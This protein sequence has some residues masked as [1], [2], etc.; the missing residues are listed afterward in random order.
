MSPTTPSIHKRFYAEASVSAD[1]NGRCRVLLDGRGVRTPGKRELAVPS[2]DLAEA[3]AEEWRSQ[4][5]NIDPTSMPM[6]R[7]ANSA[8]DGVAGREREVR[9]DLL[10]FAG[11]DLLCYLADGPPELA[12]RQSRMWGAIHAWAKCTHGVEL[13]LAVGI[14]PVEQPTEMMARLDAAFGE[15]SALELAGLH[16]VTTLTGSALLALAVL[17]EKVTAAEAWSLA[18]IDEDFQIERWGSDEEASARRA[19]RWREMEAACRVV[20]LS[21]R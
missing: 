17:H 12:E 2:A 4:G 1:V 11:S 20:M 10:A 13:E 7:I 5:S 3:I 8:I 15:R 9:A 14:M 19:M 18:H 6:T 21:A 16:V